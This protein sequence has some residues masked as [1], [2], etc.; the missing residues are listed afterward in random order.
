MPSK[1]A[2]RAPDRLVVDAELRRDRDGGERIA[3]VE[4][5]GQ[6]EIYGERRQPFAVHVKRLRVPS[7]RTSSRAHVRS[8][9]V[10]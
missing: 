1:L 3:H 2:K 9:P 4:D 10:P 6:R 8:S 5:P 7:S